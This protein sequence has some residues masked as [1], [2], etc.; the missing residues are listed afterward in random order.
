MTQ[1]QQLARI[2]AARPPAGD[3]VI[4]QIDRGYSLWLWL[5]PSCLAQSEAE[6]WKVKEKRT[7]PHKLKCDGSACKQAPA[8]TYGGEVRGP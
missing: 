5:C 2:A 7:P 8:T 1:S 3:V 6:G 4:V